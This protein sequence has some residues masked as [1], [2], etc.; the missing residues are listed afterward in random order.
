MSKQ[1][2][3]NSGAKLI[4]LSTCWPIGTQKDRIVVSAILVE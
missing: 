1:F 2:I 4:N 3:D